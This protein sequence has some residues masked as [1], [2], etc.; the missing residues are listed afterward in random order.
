MRNARTAA[1]VALLIATLGSAAAK[2]PRR[3]VYLSGPSALAEL[4]KSNP[5]HYARA[6]RILAAAPGICAAGPAEVHFARFGASDLSCASM[7]LMTSYP[8][9]QEL[10]F[11]LD[12][13]RYIAHVVVGDWAPRFYPAR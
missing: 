4:Q 13:T 5:A 3:V 8:P 11:T 12:D 10:A 2:E 6:Q 7:I 1:G 9:K